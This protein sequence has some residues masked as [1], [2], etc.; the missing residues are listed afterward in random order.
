MTKHSFGRC[1][2]VAGAM[3]VAAALSGCVVVPAY[4]PRFGYFRPHPHYYY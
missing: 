3:L 2:R 4:G 1:L